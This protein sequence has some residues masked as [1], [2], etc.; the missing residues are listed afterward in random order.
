MMNYLWAG[1]LI[2]GIIFS[3]LNHNLSEFTDSLMAD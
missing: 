3:A 1:M 2:I